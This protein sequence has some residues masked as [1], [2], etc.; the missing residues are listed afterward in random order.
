VTGT[1]TITADGREIV[2]PTSYSANEDAT[3]LDAADTGGSVG[4]LTVGYATRDAPS[5][6][7]RLR[8]K[9]IAVDD[10]K[11]GQWIGVVQSS[12]GGRGQASLTA[13]SRLTLL[14]VT[15]T[16][17]PQTGTLSA[18]I[19][20]YLGLC[21]IVDHYA[22]PSA[23]DA[24]TVSL[25]GWR[26]QV[27]LRLKQLAAVYQFEIALVS[28]NVIFRLP[29]AVVAQTYRDSDVQWSSA[30]G[31][32]ARS[33]TVR[34]YKTTSFTDGAVYP[35][36]RSFDGT[37][38]LAVEANEVKEF[39]LSLHASCSSIVQPVATDETYDNTGFS[40]SEFVISD[41]TGH[42]VLPKM[43]ADYGG[44]VVAR[45]G[46]KDDLGEWINDTRTI[47]LTVTGM[48][49]AGLGPYTFGLPTGDGNYEPAL[50]ILGTGVAQEQRSITVETGLPDDLVQQDSGAV[51]DVEAVQSEGDA[52]TVASR[53]LPAL[54][55][56]TQ[57][58]SGV[59][60]GINRL[61][62]SGSF[63]ADSFGDY[64]AAHPGQTFA[65]FDA[66]EAGVT[67]FGDFD[68]EQESSLADTFPNQAFGNVNGARR[69]YDDAWYRI[70]SASLTRA[71]VQY[72]A[73]MDTVLSD[74]DAVWAGKTFA[75][76]DAAWAG[77]TFAD[78]EVAP[79]AAGLPA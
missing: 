66:Q 62:A 15:R 75:D 32:L 29:R 2:N 59:T 44:R 46:Y 41:A 53:A 1:L 37:D 79:L 19:T 48:A 74:F 35:P 13:N 61:G 71:S 58:I 27:W 42:I 31:S 20:Y 21:G 39:V 5:I 33:L 78:F 36:N 9:V 28:D 8:R 49:L 26:D 72:T 73:T 50:T 54:M 64:D 16:A 12:N 6:A 68:A 67:T 40:R 14:A 24:I 51:I 3:P 10:R 47:T 22:M 34:W 38:L 69:F 70:R 55:G 65:Q 25:P 45:L 56:A 77:A 11:L 52:F 30:D 63:A 43:W 57:T 76:F 23:F 7:K 17:D 4:G 18:A 60:T